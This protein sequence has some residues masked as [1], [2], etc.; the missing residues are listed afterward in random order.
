MILSRTP[1]RVSFFGGSSDY[2]EWYEQHGGCVLTSSIAYYC[3]LSARWLP[4]F[5]GHRH[6]VVWSK[7]EAV[8]AVHQIEHPAVRAV[9]EYLEITDGVEIHHT[10]DL[11]ARSGL[12]SSS[13]FTVGLL[14][15]LYALQGHHMSKDALADLAVHVEQRVMRETVGIQDQIECARGGLNLIE[16]RRDGSYDVSPVILP[17]RKMLALER[18]LMLFFTGISRTASG[19]AA[20][21]IA[22]MGGKV[23]ELSE[24][25]RMVWKA[26]DILVSG[27]LIDLGPL[28][29]ESWVLKRGIAD[30]V[31]TPEVDDYYAAARSAGATGGKLLGAGGG[32][33]LLIF[34]PPERQASVRFSLSGLVEVPFRFDHGGTRIMLS[35]SPEERGAT[36]ERPSLQRVRAQPVRTS[37]QS[38]ADSP[39]Q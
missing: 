26:L 10:G 9:L 29:H 23:A 37:F 31:S 39:D 34:C 1:Y 11:P 30:A 6:R 22:G 21:Q 25:G 4:P 14:H 7:V 13:A 36:V 12:G 8:D 28:L 2:R 5:H 17:L 19:I 35:E 33:F 32:G 3:W 38:S 24:M 18:H 16:I 20:Q 15:A 27:D